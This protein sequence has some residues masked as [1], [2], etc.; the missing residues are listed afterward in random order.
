MS[1][2]KCDVPLHDVSAVTKFRGCCGP[3]AVQQQGRDAGPARSLSLRI[4]FDSDLLLP[5]SFSCLVGSLVISLRKLRLLDHRHLTHCCVVS[6]IPAHPGLDH[7]AQT[8]SLAVCMTWSP[9]CL[10]T[11]HL[12]SLSEN[13]IP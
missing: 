2:R 12:R 11:K 1:V 7:A 13:I 5:F 6:P 8:F 3:R 4:S 10:T 9:G